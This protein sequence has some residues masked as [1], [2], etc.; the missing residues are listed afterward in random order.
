[1]RVHETGQ[2]ERLA[3]VDLVGIGMGCAQ[4][5]S[6]A[7]GSNFTLCD[8]NAAPAVMDRSIRGHHVKRG[9]GEPQRLADMKCFLHCTS[10]ER[11]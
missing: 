3:M 4:I 7:Q 10:F 8:Q 11:D 1:M 9:G 2:D 5:T 6:R